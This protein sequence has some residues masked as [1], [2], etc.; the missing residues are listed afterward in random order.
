M[1][2]RGRINVVTQG[3][4]G[5]GNA[6][7]NIGPGKVSLTDNTLPLQLTGEAKLNQLIFYAVL[8]G[9]LTGSLSNPA[10]TF[11]PGAILRSHGRVMDTLDIDEIRWPLAGVHISSQG[12]D[13][14][15]NAIARAR[16]RQMGDMELHLDGTATAFKPDEGLWQWRYWGKGHFVPM[17][18][19]WDVKGTGE[20]RNNI[21]IINTLSTGFNKLQYGSMLI[22]KPRLELLNPLYWHREINKE[23]LNGDFTL[24]TGVID[25][26][27]GSH[28]PPTR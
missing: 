22:N 26:G 5:K 13:G 7:L 14:R 3:T 10:I 1:I 12:V 2:I 23:H 8:P 18:A 11:K 6:V 9:N 27:S 17:Q 21:F 25:F 4:A 24:N 28:L 20:W 16:N 15:L 19:K